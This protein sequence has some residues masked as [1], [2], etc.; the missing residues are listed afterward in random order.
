MTSDDWFVGNDSG[1]PVE[2]SGKY[3]VTWKKR[4]GYWKVVAESINRD[5]PRV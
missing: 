3:L 5:S 4:G 2:H 1:K